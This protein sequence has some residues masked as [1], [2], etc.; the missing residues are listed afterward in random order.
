M[1]IAEAINECDGAPSQTKYPRVDSNRASVQKNKGEK[2]SLYSFSEK[3]RAKKRKKKY[4]H[5][6]NIKNPETQYCMIH[7]A[8]NYSGEWKVLEDYGN[9][10]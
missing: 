8:G 2:S 9:K 6:S 5:C 3:K 10:Y 1:E 7:G 4:V